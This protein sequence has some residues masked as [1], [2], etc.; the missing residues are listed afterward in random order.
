MH[1]GLLIQFEIPR[2]QSLDDNEGLA[3]SPSPNRVI[4]ARGPGYSIA[5]T[6]PSL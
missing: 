2:A 1:E 6:E 5:T 3:L 4:S